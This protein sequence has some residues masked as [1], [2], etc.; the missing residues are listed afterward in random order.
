ML[1]AGTT[2][3]PLFVRTIALRL[4]FLSAAAVA[5][6]LGD[7]DLAAYQVSMQTWFLLA[8]G[9]DAS[10]SRV[11]RWSAAAGWRRCRRCA[12][13]G[14]A[15]VLWSLG[16]GVVLLLAVLALRVPYASI[17]TDDADVAALLTASLVVVALMQPLAGP[18]FVWDGIL[19]GAGDARWLAW[20]QI[21]TYAV[22]AGRLVGARGG[23]R[24]GGLVV[25][26]VLVH[27]R[28]GL[29][30]V[31]ADQVRGMGGARRRALR[32][33][34]APLRGVGLHVDLENNPNKWSLRP[35]SSAWFS[36]LSLHERLDRRRR[37]RV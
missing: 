2:S 27:G 17:F 24:S 7:A 19:I 13:G 12:R 5:A 21:V 28:A 6:R 35:M 4:V 22:P 26:A 31:A 16:L 10:R 34:R 11:R 3:A 29:A 1:A 33:R 37:D 32:L 36:G 18:G 9:M 30:A 15:L 14:A 8:L 20:A 25:G 23:S